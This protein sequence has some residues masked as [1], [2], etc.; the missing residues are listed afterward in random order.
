MNTQGFIRGMMAK[1]YSSEKFL[2][3]VATTVERQLQE[4]NEQFEIMVAK[5]QNNFWIVRNGEESI[6]FTITEQEVEQLQNKSPYSL[7]RRIWEELENHG[8]DIKIGPGNYMSYVF[9]DRR[10]D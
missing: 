10:E 6:Y 4:W 3:H 1:N 8:I 5:L 2:V 9:P 7:D